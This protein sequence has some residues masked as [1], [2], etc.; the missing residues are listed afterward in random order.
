MAQQTPIFLTVGD[1]RLVI[2]PGGYLR[3]VQTLR[4][5]GSRLLTTGVLGWVDARSDASVEAQARA[6]A[7]YA[8][9]PEGVYEAAGGVEVTVTK[10]GEDA[11]RMQDEE[12]IDATYD[13]KK[14]IQLLLGSEARRKAAVTAGGLDAAILADRAR[15]HERF[16]AGG[17]F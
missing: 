12:G 2:N 9:A 13:R 11:Y 10:T 17:I 3:L 6:L 8:A 14:T 5:D 1:Q 7:D 15:R 4:E 16:D